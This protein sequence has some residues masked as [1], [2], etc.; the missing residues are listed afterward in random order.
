MCLFVLMFVVIMLIC[1]Y[2]RDVNMSK[3]ISRS[4]KETRFFPLA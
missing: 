3:K 2:V 4:I 1:L